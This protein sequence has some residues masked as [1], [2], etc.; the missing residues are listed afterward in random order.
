MI[1]ESEAARAEAREAGTE[2]PEEERADLT[3]E[4]VFVQEVEGLELIQRLGLVVDA[5][6][7]AEKTAVKNDELAERGFWDIADPHVT[8]SV[9]AREAAMFQTAL[10]ALVLLAPRESRIFKMALAMSSKFKRDGTALWDEVPEEKLQEQ[11]KIVAAIERERAE[12]MKRAFVEAMG[13]DP[14][15][16]QIFDEE[17]ATLASL[18]EDELGR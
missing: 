2:V 3:D 17:E 8:V 5:F 7:N 16:V 10:G 12:E 9:G 13:L 6:K 11:D 1:N 4:E 15:S 14:D 18:P